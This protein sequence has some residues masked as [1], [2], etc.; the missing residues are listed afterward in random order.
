MRKFNAAVGENFSPGNFHKIFFCLTGQQP[1][2]TYVCCEYLE[3]GLMAIDIQMVVVHDQRGLNEPTAVIVQWKL[4]R[5]GATLMYLRHYHIG[6]VWFAFSL[7][8]CGFLSHRWKNTFEIL[9]LFSI[10]FCLLAHLI[11]L[12]FVSFLAKGTLTF[13]N[14][15]DLKF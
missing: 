12:F 6:S 3:S 14:F 8:S 2:L 15:A 11:F 1:W 9:I 4:V 5:H 7:V 13:V 10:K